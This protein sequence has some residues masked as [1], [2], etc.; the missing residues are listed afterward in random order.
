MIGHVVIRQCP[1]YFTFDE[2]EAE[3]L[4]N[5]LAHSIEEAYAIIDFFTFDEY[6]GD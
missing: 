2:E 5:S 6:D 1:L 4:I 3:F